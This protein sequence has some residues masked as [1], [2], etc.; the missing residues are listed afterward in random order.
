MEN[1]SDYWKNMG[2]LWSKSASTLSTPA[3]LEPSMLP[4]MPYNWPAQ[5][6]PFNYFH[7]PMTI[8]PSTAAYPTPEF[9]AKIS[10]QNVEGKIEEEKSIFADLDEK[11]IVVVNSSNDTRN[12]TINSETNTS[13]N[14]GSTTPM[15]FLNG[16]QENHGSEGSSGEKLIKIE[17]GENFQIITRTFCREKIILKNSNK[18]FLYNP[19]FWHESN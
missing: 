12:S 10:T 14:S 8:L 17:V 19:Y 16:Q 13:T 3:G 7:D 6:L 5:T 18:F 11:K 2:F 15:T 1:S 9:L 4:S